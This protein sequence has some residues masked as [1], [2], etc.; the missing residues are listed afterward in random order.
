M[1]ALRPVAFLLCLLLAGCTAGEV[2]RSVR[3][4]A[5]GNPTAAARIAGERAARYAADPEALVRDLDRL[6]QTFEDFRKLVTGSW[7]KKQA[8]EPSPKT[9]VKYTQNYESRASVDFDSGVVKV[10]TLA[11]KNPL[12]SLKNAVVTTLL[13][14]D[15]PRSVDLFSDQEV[16]LSGTPFLQ[17]EVRDQHGGMIKTPK[18]A[19]AFADYLVKNRLHSKSIHTPKGSRT[20]RYVQ[21]DLVKDHLQVRAQKYAP[22]V[23]EQARRFGVSSNLVFAIIKVESDFNPFAVSS[24]GAIGLMQV[25]PSSAGEDVYAY[26]N[27]K[28]GRPSGDSLTAPEVN[29]RYGTAYLHLLQDRYLSK[30]RNPTSR[31]YCVIAAYNTGAGNT[32]RSFS[33]NRDKAFQ[34]VNELDPLSVYKTLRSHLPYEETRRYIQKVMAAKKQ[35]INL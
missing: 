3:A 21:F 19:E 10:E 15:D 4:A 11:A 34:R 33:K 9:Y 28:A 1:K 29:I 23:R 26:L 32:L 24:A 5:S 22:L 30:V 6:Q 8:K 17:G 14:P 16:Q 13:T 31:E 18:Q 12:T 27:G 7:G 2:L 20:L 35:F 25:V